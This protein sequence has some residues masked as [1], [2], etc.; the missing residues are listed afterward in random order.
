MLMM[1]FVLI[2]M[3]HTPL[4]C[5]LCSTCHCTVH[6]NSSTSP[7]PRVRTARW[8]RRRSC[9][10]PRTECRSP[11][12]IAIGGWCGSH[13]AVA[14]PSTCLTASPRWWRTQVPPPPLMR[15]RPDPT[16]R[17]KW[18]VGRAAS[19]FCWRFCRLMDTVRVCACCVGVY[20]SRRISTTC[21]TTSARPQRQTRSWTRCRTCV[22]RRGLRVSK[23]VRH[24]RWVCMQD[25]RSDAGGGDD[26]VARSP[27]L[28]ELEPVTRA[29]VGAISCPPVQFSTR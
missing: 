19:H 15:M 26:V 6:A 8:S 11:A 28:E 21:W 17:W 16:A 25:D 20:R 23:R 24:R 14:M 29:H 22:P 4:S 7:S 18:C 9:F 10:G 27:A 3:V 2:P 13:Q 12:T 5:R 1:M